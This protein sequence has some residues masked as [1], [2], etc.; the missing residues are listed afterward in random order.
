MSSVLQRR[1]P[2]TSTLGLFALRLR[3]EL[4]GVDAMQRA[5]VVEIGP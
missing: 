4:R 2:S 5:A 3:V 1:I